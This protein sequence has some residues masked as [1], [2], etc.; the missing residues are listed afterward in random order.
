MQALRFRFFLLLF[1]GIWLSACGQRIESPDSESTAV[2]DAAAAP[3]GTAAAVEADGDGGVAN[4]GANVANRGANVANRGA[5]TANWW[6]ALPRQEWAAFERLDDGSGWFEIYRVRPDVLAFYESGQFE[7]VVSYLILGSERALLFDSGLG[8]GDLR[9]AVS[10]LTD[11]PVVVL[12][13]HSHYD[14]IGGN[15]QF[16]FIYGPDH[17]YT[18]ERMAGASN[19]QVAEFVSPAWIHKPLP[20]GFD[21]AAFESRPYRI[22]EF[23]TEGSVIDLGGRE[24]T[25]LLTPGHAPDALCLLDRDRRLLFTGDTFYPAPLYTH[26]PG[27]DFVAYRASAKRLAALAPLVNHLLPGHNQGL[28]GS[29]YLIRMADA[30]DAVAAGKGVYVETEGNREYAFENFSIIVA[31]DVV[32][33]A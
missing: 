33:G 20:A 32:P 31:P 10:P 3:G 16:D 4:R 26:I 6:D 14:H 13:S 2:A 30:F 17:P 1:A 25:V 22:D 27:G 19:E 12:N 28:V 11:L 23:V 8:I 7:E 18:R 24:L 5:N 21:P 15:H 9:A 29:E